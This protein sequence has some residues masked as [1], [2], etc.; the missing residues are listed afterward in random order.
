MFFSEAHQT[1]VHVLFQNTPSEYERQK[2]TVSVVL[3][4]T[5]LPGTGVTH[6]HPL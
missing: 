4:L 1:T 3:R 2:R 6:P 5:A